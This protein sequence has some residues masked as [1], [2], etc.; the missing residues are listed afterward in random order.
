VPGTHEY[1]SII[2][3][4]MFPNLRGV[5]DVPEPESTEPMRPLDLASPWAGELPVERLLPNVPPLLS[6]RLYRYQ[7]VDLG[8]LAARL[9]ADGG[10]YLG[11]DRGL[12][13]TLGSIILAYELEARR[14]LIIANNQAKTSIWLPE[15]SKWTADHVSLHNIAGNKK[16]RDAVMNAWQYD[17]NTWAW[18]VIHPEA[19]RLIDWSKYAPMDL[20][21]FDEAH[22][23]LHGGVTSSRGVPQ[24]YKSLKKIPSTYRLA[25]SGSIIVNSWEDAFGAIHWLFPKRYRSRWRDWND[26]FLKYVNG[27][28]HRT[29][30]DLNRDQIDTMRNELG[31]FMTVRHKQDTLDGL[32]DVI[33]QDMFVDLTGEQQ[34]VYHEMATRL[35]AD[36]PEDNG[37][38]RAQNALTQIMK[39]RQIACGLD[40]FGD[41][42]DSAKIDAA[43]ELV[44][45]NLPHATVCFTWHRASADALEAR[46]TKLGIPTVKVHG[47]VPLKD[48]TAAIDR[49]QE[50]RAKAFV[51]TIKTVGESVNLNAASDVVF[52][53]SSWTPADMDQARDRVAGGLRQSGRSRRISVTRII[54]RGTVDETR[55]LPALR[56]KATIRRLVLGGS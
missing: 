56:D 13:K 54:S 41:I 21:V 32:P 27:N 55:V 3:V 30:V 28:G 53:E 46:L 20:V 31:A 2:A 51:G 50:G 29:L 35:V 19:L 9:R 26:R 6:E 44:Q 16:Q 11:W 43:V 18:A 34:R 22:K 8:F 47:D 45:E 39:L 38:I 52:V 12:G 1:D 14:T 10:A 7:A 36:L 37:K 17:S 33:E 5:V 40:L 42:Q 24:F 48:R 49:F 15:V 25:L 4:T 23:L